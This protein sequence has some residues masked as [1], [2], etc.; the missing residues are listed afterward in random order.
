MIKVSVNPPNNGYY[1]VIVLWF[2]HIL[3]FQS[4]EELEQLTI[5][6]KLGDLE[7]AIYILK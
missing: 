1:I 5:D 4:P 7:R 2:C 6:E 3:N